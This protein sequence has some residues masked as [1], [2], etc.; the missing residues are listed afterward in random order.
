MDFTKKFGDV[1]LHADI[2]DKNP[3]LSKFHMNYKPF[4]KE[5]VSKLSLWSGLPVG[6]SYEFAACASENPY[7]TWMYRILAKLWGGDEDILKFGKRLLMGKLYFAL[8]ALITERG[9]FEITV[10]IEYLSRQDEGFLMHHLIA[11][12][13]GR[14]ILMGRNP[15]CMSC[16]CHLPPCEESCYFQDLVANACDLAEVFKN[17][18]IPDLETRWSKLLLDRKNSGT[19]ES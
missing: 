1:E 12:S 4:Y 15:S 10:P 2:S 8:V 3:G 5:L 13:L 14:Q 11:T 19:V 9:D 17:T 6:D 16:S 18:R 7:L